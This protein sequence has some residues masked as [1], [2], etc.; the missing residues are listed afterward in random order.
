MIRSGERKTSDYSL[1]ALIRA[2]TTDKIRED[3]R[4]EM[5]AA[6]R[7]YT[8]RRNTLY[9][10]TASG[11]PAAPGDSEGKSLEPA[12]SSG[13]PAWAKNFERDKLLDVEEVKPWLPGQPLT[14]YGFLVSFNDCCY[15]RY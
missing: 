6:S 4:R 12:I 7:R 11:V 3:A 8:D 10:F 15:F 1:D 13:P 9:G 5:Q 2:M 14:R